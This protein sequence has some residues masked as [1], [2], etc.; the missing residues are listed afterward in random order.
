MPF[1]TYL[2]LFTLLWNTKGDNTFDYEVGSRV[3]DTIKSYFN[4]ISEA[5]TLP[6]I[7][8]K[9]RLVNISISSESCPVLF[10]PSVVQYER[11]ISKLYLGLQTGELDL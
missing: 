2:Y 7:I 6:I 3:F 8:T 4:K 10:F 11:I 1:L 9:Q 5:G